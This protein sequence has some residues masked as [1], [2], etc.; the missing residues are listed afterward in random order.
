MKS[1]R[2]RDFVSILSEPSTAWVNDFL[3]ADC[4][5]IQQQ[6]LKEKRFLAWSQWMTTFNNTELLHFL[7]DECSHAI[8][9]SDKAHLA[10]N[11]S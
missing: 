9:T 1:Y 2:S 8:E 11:L 7:T 3:Q 4:S 10:R 6:K 5:Q